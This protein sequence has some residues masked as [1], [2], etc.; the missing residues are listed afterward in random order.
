MIQTQHIAAIAR[1]NVLSG[2]DFSTSLDTWH[3]ADELSGDAIADFGGVDLTDTTAM[4]GS[5]T[6]A[7][8]SGGYRTSAG[9]H[10]FEIAATPATSITLAGWF[11]VSASA[12]YLMTFKR[13]SDSEYFGVFGVGNQHIIRVH[14]DDDESFSVFK[15]ESPL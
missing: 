13:T 9:T 4:S 3:D 15:L 1:K 11:Y 12:D 6:G 10:H 8:D 7:P 14:D 2:T 5:A